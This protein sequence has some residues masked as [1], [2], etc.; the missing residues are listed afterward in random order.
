MSWWCDILVTDFQH[1][2]QSKAA[3][4]WQALPHP[5]SPCLHVYLLE[6][7]KDVIDDELLGLIGVHPSEWVQINHS[8]F[9]PNEWESQGTFQGLVREERKL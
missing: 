3:W 8:I 9:K 1:P 2:K 7:L 5:T 6:V 4:P